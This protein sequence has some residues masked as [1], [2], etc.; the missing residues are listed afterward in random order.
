MIHTFE[1]SKTI[2]AK[3]FYELNNSLS[4]IQRI[5]KYNSSFHVTYMYK[6]KGLSRITLLKT[7]RERIAPDYPNSIYYYN[8]SLIINPLQMFGG[9]KN[10]SS[11][12]YDFSSC[13]AYKILSQIY[14]I[15]PSLEIFP[16]LRNVNDIDSQKK[17]YNANTFTVKRIDF[18]FDIK[19]NCDVYLDIIKRGYYIPKLESATYSNDNTQNNKD[20]K[21][22][23]D[24]DEIIPP[25]P[26]YL[27]YKCKSYNLN[28]YNKAYAMRNKKT[29]PKDYEKYDFLRF[30]CQVKRRKLYYIKEKL[31]LNGLDILDLA[32]PEVEHYFLSSSLNARLGTGIHLTLESARNII[33]ECPNFKPSKR[34][35]LKD[36]IYFINIHGGIEKSLDLVKQGKTTTYTE[37]TFNTYLKDIKSLGISPIT[38]PKSR[39]I[40]DSNNNPVM[41]KKIGTYLVNLST[42]YEAYYTAIQQELS[43]NYN[44]LI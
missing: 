15:L 43:A 22:E 2:T 13:L 5:N 30:E 9:D 39:I 10:F 7:K 33:D 37:S 20:D 44:N 19:N 29:L 1:L 24:S 4:G 34:K 38:I 35:R 11:C 23:Y 28:I 12:T 31:G 18:A 14:D 8:I 27:Y 17:W 3:N 42:I 41:D 25:T 36:F 32:T 21:F 26:K 16:N 40:L 6:E